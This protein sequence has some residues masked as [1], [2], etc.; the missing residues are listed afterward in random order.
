MISDL[1]IDQVLQALDER[2]LD[3]ILCNDAKHLMPAKREMQSL[4]N[5]YSR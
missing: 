1:K 3:I 2:Q 5:F 4:T